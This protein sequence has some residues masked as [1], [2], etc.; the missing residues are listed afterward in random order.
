MTSLV[1]TD[2]S[3]FAVFHDTDTDAMIQDR[4]LAESLKEKAE[5]FLR[6][7]LKKDAR[8]VK[9]SVLE[10]IRLV[11]TLMIQRTQNHRNITCGGKPFAALVY[12]LLVDSLG[13][14]ID[15]SKAKQILIRILVS[16]GLMLKE[17]FSH[18]LAISERMHEG[19]RFLQVLN[20][21]IYFQ[22]AS[23][24]L[25]HYFFRTW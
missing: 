6:S 11:S 12:N 7:N 14:E 2:V 19:L 10:A 3:I 16:T 22:S 17:S 15:R 25:F 8:Q 18:Y 13:Q 24:F 5:N 20:G 1:R 21:F 9:D 23:R 4:K